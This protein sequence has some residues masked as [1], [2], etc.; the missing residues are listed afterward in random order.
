MPRPRN[1]EGGAFCFSQEVDSSS[2][3]GGAEF[4]PNRRR[5]GRSKDLYRIQHF[6]VRKRRDPHLERDARDAAKNFVNI[7]DLFRDR[8]G[9]ADQQCPG[10]SALPIELSPCGRWPA[11]FLTDLGKR[12]RI[13]RKKY[14]RGFLRAPRKKA[15]RM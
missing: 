11:T 7:N 6:L 9:I 15:N 3:C 2:A 8:L 1:V 12:V 10:G 13:P 5:H 4:I 14:V